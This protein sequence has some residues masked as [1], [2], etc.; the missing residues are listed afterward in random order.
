MRRSLAALLL[1]CALAACK[2]EPPPPPPPPPKSTLPLH[3]YGASRVNPGIESD[4]LLD[5]AAGASVLSRT[6][7]L[8]LEASAAHSIDGLAETSWVSAPGASDETL[9]FSLL[10]PARVLRVG[11]TA[12]GE[13]RPDSVRFEGSADGVRWQD[14]ATLKPE[15]TKERQLAGVAKPMKARLI[16]IHALTSHRYYLS[17]R[18][19]HVLGEEVEPPRAPPFTGCWTVN[20]VRAHITQD[21]ARIRGVVESDPPT[22]LDGGTD[23][24]VALVTWI[25]GPTWGYAALTRSNDG[26]HLTGITFYEEIEEANVG[27][28]W[29]GDACRGGVASPVAAPETFL[30]RAGRYSLFGLVFDSREQLVEELSAPALDAVAK[31]LRDAPRQ[32]FRVTSRE[33]RYNTP[34]L[35]ARH[36]GA[37]LSALRNA[38]GA[39][40]VDTSRLELLAAGNEWL[41]PPISSAIQLLLASRI[42]IETV[43]R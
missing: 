9:V 33:F 18:A 7:E 11:V 3:R 16:R 43:S 36:T 35:N 10:A 2:K 8:S 22:F 40:G 12:P 24:R 29:F 27:E 38:L 17:A 42:D 13:Q 25:Q 20:G 19:F 23:D 14:L 37:R 26:K 34:E 39:R 1:A 21:G 5:L 15:D 30:A 28:G 6:G 4:N 32:R 41:G 31:L